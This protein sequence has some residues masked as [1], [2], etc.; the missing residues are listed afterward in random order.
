MNRMGLCI[1]ASLLLVATSSAFGQ[2]GE[3]ITGMK[4]T[5]DQPIQIESDRLDVREQDGVAE[6]TGNV[7]I[8]QGTTLLKSGKMV[9]Y[10]VKDG[11]SAATG[12]AKID[13]IEASGKVYVQSDTQI[14]T[15]DKGTFSMVDP[16]VGADRQEC[17]AFRRQ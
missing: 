12:S 16:G 17:R 4:L 6:F 15:G 9:V 11:G 8:V 10:Y 13:H 7:S 1:S 5:N 14:A 2:S 3:R